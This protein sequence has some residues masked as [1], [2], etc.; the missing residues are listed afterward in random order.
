MRSVC[1]CVDRSLGCLPCSLRLVLF[2]HCNRQYFTPFTNKI[3]AHLLDNMIFFLVAPAVW[4]LHQNPKP[5]QHLW[6]YATISCKYRVHDYHTNFPLFCP[7]LSLLLRWV[8]ANF[9]RRFFTSLAF[10]SIVARPKN[11]ILSMSSHCL[12]HCYIT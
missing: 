10:F 5:F 1:R 4:Q 8:S 2:F 3:F 7:S 11:H 12:L 6:N 9:C